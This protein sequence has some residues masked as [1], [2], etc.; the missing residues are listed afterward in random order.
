L[1]TVVCL[2]AVMVIGI[3]GL[4]ILALWRR[5]PNKE[6]DMFRGATRVLR[7][8]WQVED[9][10][11]EELSKRVASLKPSETEEEESESRRPSR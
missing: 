11:L 3:N 4:L 7:N 5:Q 10:A 1:I 2:V 8:P 9:D 6:L